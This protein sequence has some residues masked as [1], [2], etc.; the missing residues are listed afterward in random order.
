MELAYDDAGGGACVVL[1]HGHP[2]DRSLWEPQVGALAKEF[3]VLAPDL[4]GFGESPGTPHL[5]AMREYAQDV[6][7]LLDRLG[8][9]RAAIV[10]LSMGGLVAME[11]ATAHPQRC[12]ALGLV[13]TTAEPVTAGERE[14][15]RE[16]ADRVEREGMQVLI[17]YMHTGVYGP[18]C[19]P[20]VRER[21]D[22]MMARAPVQGAAAALRGRAER[23]DYRLLLRQL[24]LPAFVCTGSADPWSNEAVTAEIVNHLRRPELVVIDGAGHL[25]NLEAEDEF[26]GALAAFL[27]QHAPR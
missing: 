1:I 9:D 5:V 3:R 18:R 14:L 10:G 7:E 19:P 23:P 20:A 13:T 6:L 15:R 2:F 8:I 21:V 17:D 22:A 24:D 4:R 27:T 26:N 12:W 11:L 25:P 16:R